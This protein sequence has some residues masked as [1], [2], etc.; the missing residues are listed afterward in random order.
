M[1]DDV[2]V[3][4]AGPAGAIA[5]IVLARAG[6]RVRL[7]DRAVFPRDKMCGDSLNPGAIRLLARHGLD[8]AVTA[9][10][11]P[12]EGMLLTGPGGA[13]VEGR[14]PGGVLGRSILRRDLDWLLLEAAIACGARVE[15]G[16]RVVGPVVDG[17]GASRTVRG[18]V[19]VGQTTRSVE[20]RAPV[21][22]AADGRHSGLAFQLSLARHPTRPRRWA[23]GAYFENVGGLTPLGEMHVRRGAYI[24][25]AAVPGGLTNACLVL[26]EVAARAVMRNPEAALGDRLSSDP[27][28]SRRF[29]TARRVTKAS[30]LGPLAV[31]TTGAGLPGLLLAGDAA[32]FIDPMTGDGLRI[33]MRGG[34]LAAAAA[35][36]ALG[37]RERTSDPWQLEVQRRRELGAK[38]RVNRALRAFVGVPVGVSAAALI[39]PLAPSILQRLIAYAGDVG[40]GSTLLPTS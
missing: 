21:V 18:V 23:I 35:L 26:P 13:A 16:V 14:Y 8:Q 3:V 1:P 32:G 12:V 6:A 28:L 30:V 33:A 34:E 24:G 40:V 31:E 25:V 2:I 10:G 19:A 27:Q 7:L 22:I 5:A 38:L 37:A 11:L 15:Q 17:A 36:E 20:R 4:G 29:A 9:C 39:A